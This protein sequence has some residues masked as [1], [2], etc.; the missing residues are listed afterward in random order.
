MQLTI[1]TYNIRHGAGMD[2]RWNPARPAD[3]VRKF[4]PDVLCLQE[5][6][7]HTGRSFGADEPAM[8][9]HFLEPLGHWAFVKSIDYEGGEYGNA[10]LA[11]EEAISIIRSPLPGVNEGRSVIACEFEPY[12]V[13]TLHAS[14]HD[15]TRL[16]SV[17]TLVRLSRTFDKPLFIT[18][19]WNATP[20]S[21]F[22]AAMRDTFEILS[23]TEFGT[24]P[25]N[26]PRVCIDY[27]AVDKAHANDVRVVEAFVA[28]EPLASDHRPVV[29]RLEVA[30]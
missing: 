5:V 1:M 25:A 24:C 28:D 2:N 15:E 17:D 9:A 11:R 16:Q 22:L 27:V 12:A 29:V 4:E 23:P 18:G 14:L 6:D 13:A 19:D 8:L 3:V 21:P 26:K 20:D 7:R 30:C 10:L